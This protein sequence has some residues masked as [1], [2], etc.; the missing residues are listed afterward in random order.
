VSHLS[1]LSRIQL[2]QHV[3][4][5][6]KSQ[7]SRPVFAFVSAESVR[8]VEAGI[9]KGWEI[10]KPSHL[11][12]ENPMLLESV[13]FFLRFKISKISLSLNEKSIWA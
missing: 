6:T 5:R 1:I 9:I 2:N 4:R 11:H 12:Q 8:A 10:V 7:K 3:L 13:L